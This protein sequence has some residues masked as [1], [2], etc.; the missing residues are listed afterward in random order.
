[1]NFRIAKIS[2]AKEIAEIHMICADHQKDG[3]MHKLGIKFLIQYYKI[4]INENNSIIVVAENEG[5]ICGFHSGTALEEEHQTS[6]KRN[7]FKLAITL[8]QKLLL[9]PKM[10]IDIFGRY[11]SLSTKK[12]KY[13]VTSGPRGE[14]WAW[15]PSIKNP[16]ASMILRKTWANVMH[17]LGNK[18]FKFEVDL[19]NSDVNKYARAFSC[20]VLEV[21]NL[22][23]GRKRAIMEQVFKNKK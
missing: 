4:F 23:D 15:L 6:I 11:K 20:N 1:M 14:Y 22:P 16:A 17:D 3:F 5:V 21:N 2:D 12:S 19:S 18:S 9:N 13:R 8:L 7:K 10:A